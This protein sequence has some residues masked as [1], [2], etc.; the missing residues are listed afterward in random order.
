M[1]QAAALMGRL[2]T[3]CAPTRSRATGR[4]RRSSAST[5]WCSRSTRDG[6]ATA[7]YTVHRAGRPGAVFANAGT[8][9]RSWSADR[10][11]RLLDERR[12]PPLGSA[13]VRRVR[14]DR[15]DVAPGE[16]LCST[17]TGW[18]SAGASRSRDAR[19]AAR[20]R[21]RAPS[22]ADELCERIDE[23]LVAAEE[24][25]TMAVLAL[26]ACRVERPGAALAR[27]ARGAHRGAPGAA[28]LAAGA[29]RRPRGA[30]RHH[31]RARRGVHQRD[32]ARLSPGRGKLRL[33]AGTPTTS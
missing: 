22:T 6:M 1:A 25:T 27:R 26:R 24:R 8:C 11:P 21:P 23:L 7:A 13:A 33:E 15:L 10:Q 30:L 9:R 4:Q 18:S 16:S 31:A 17:P 5:A 20:W 19:A 3:R 14:R 29:R 2:R 12:R 32:R 28:P